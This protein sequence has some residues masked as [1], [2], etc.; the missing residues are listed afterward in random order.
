MRYRKDRRPKTED[1]RRALLVLAGLA[2]V[3]VFAGC[4]LLNILL[5]TDKTPPTCQ[6]TSPADSGLVNGL[7]SITANATDSGGIGR[8][9]F[10]ADGALVGADSSSP[11][12]GSWDASGQAER[13][14]HKLSCIA[15]DLSQNKGYS[16]TIAVQIAAVGQKSVYH[17]ELDV[18]AQSREAVQFDAQAGDTLSGDA[19]VASGG[20]LSSFMWL[21]NDNYQ[22]Y[23]ANQ[24]YTALF[25]RDNFTQTSM[26]QAVPATGGYY[27]VFVNAG[28]AV[29]KCWARFVLE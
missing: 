5:G 3:A 1:R 17:G 13:S 7:V 14:W 15:Y 25:Q 27:I 16:D 23:V 28:N 6:I 19:Q 9:E 29:V 11:Y 26:R 20:T 8:V 21:D 18:A 22:K 2:A 4:D 10:Y 24:A 12:S